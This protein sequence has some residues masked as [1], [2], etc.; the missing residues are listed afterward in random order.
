MKTYLMT[1]PSFEGEVEF[2]YN[3]LD[4]LQGFDSSRALLSEKQQ[5]W[6]LK[7]FPR[8]LLEA[9]KL[10]KDNPAIKFYE[11]KTDITFEMFWS[12]YNEKVRSSKKKSLAKWSRISKIEQIKCYQ[13]ISIYEKS[14]QSGVY[15]K[16]AETYLQS[17]L[18]NN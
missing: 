18:W 5:V 16:Y 17:E 3:D 14:I 4:L 2:V 11:L 12:R 13:F 8:E 9:E 6:I 1:S 7:N 10:L 15:K